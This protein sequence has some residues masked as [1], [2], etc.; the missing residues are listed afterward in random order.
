MLFKCPQTSDW[1]SHLTDYKV[2]NK[3]VQSYGSTKNWIMLDIPDTNNITVI[4]MKG[5]YRKV[6]IFNIY[7]DCTH[8]R[9]ET[10]LQRYIKKNANTILGTKNHHMI[11]A[12]DFNRHHPLWD[13]NKDTYLF[14]QQAIRAAEGLI[15][16]IA[17][18]NLDMALPK[19][20]PPSSIW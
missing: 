4:Q 9:N 13:N 17:M 10:I 2:R 18:F 3:Y 20:I 7:N 11:W 6:S 12:G 19:K 16:L 14:T 1:S 5:P 15:E 8:S